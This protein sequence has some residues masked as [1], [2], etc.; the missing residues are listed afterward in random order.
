MRLYRGLDPFLDAYNRLKVSFIERELLNR[1]NALRQ[2][3]RID[4][5]NGLVK[6][7][8]FGVSI[9]A[10]FSRAV[11]SSYNPESRFLTTAHFLARMPSDDPNRRLFSR[12]A[13]PTFLSK[14]VVSASMKL[15][16]FA[17]NVCTD[18]SLPSDLRRRFVFI[19]DL[20]APRLLRLILLMTACVMTDARLSNYTVNIA[21]RLSPATIFNDFQESLRRYRALGR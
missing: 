2:Q 3:V 17:S 11:R 4:N 21:L 9:K 15:S 19:D 10:A 6:G 8:N 20:P 7:F 5:P 16:S 12:R 13:L 1:P 14:M 18:A